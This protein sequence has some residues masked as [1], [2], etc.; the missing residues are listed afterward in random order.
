MGC[1]GGNGDR[2]QTPLTSL[3]VDILTADPP[4]G[5]LGRAVVAVV[6]DELGEAGRGDVEDLERAV[7]V[8]MADPRH[9]V[10]LLAGGQ[11]PAQGDG[12][13]AGGETGHRGPCGA[14]EHY[15]LHRC[16]DKI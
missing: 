7:G 5:V 4:R 6:V 13:R 16:I 1:V 15:L 8:H 11:V 14:G 3:D 10:D 2:V 9:V 12:R